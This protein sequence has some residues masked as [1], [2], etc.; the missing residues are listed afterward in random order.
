MSR[1]GAGASGAAPSQARLLTLVRHAR[2]EPA[3]EGRDDFERALD[4]RGRR[5][6]VALA[7][8]LS[9][10]AEGVPPVDRVLCSDAAR[11]RE[12]LS[13]VLPALGAAGER[14]SFERALYLATADAL[15]ER[16]A[17]AL[18]E[19]ARHVL[20]VGHNPGLEALCARLAGAPGLAMDTC[21]RF[22]LRL[23]GAALDPGAA[24]VAAH[25]VPRG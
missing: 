22:T 15:A 13:P 18:A 6:A 21:A 23:D 8:L 1:P 14:A 10:Q 17:R 2:A 25:D 7:A 12:T 20:L 19:G 24:T 3:T 5:D 11:A 16:A 4:A 9:T